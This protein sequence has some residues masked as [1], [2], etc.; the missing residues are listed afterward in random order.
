MF[1]GEPTSFDLCSVIELQKIFILF[2][3]LFYF[4]NIKY[5]NA[6]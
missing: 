1:C 5:E 2:I 3:Y 4:L 6:D